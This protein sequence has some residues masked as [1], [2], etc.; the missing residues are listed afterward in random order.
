[1]DD[2]LGA[3]GLRFERDGSLGWCIIDRPAAPRLSLIHI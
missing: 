1:M 2:D 3:A